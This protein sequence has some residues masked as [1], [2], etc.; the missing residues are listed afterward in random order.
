MS[1]PNPKRRPMKKKPAPRTPSP[2]RMAERPPDEAPIFRTVPAYTRWLGGWWVNA[3]RLTV[4]HVV[5]GGKVLED[6]TVTADRL[7]VGDGKRRYIVPVCFFEA[8]A[9]MGLLRY[10]GRR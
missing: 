3:A 7:M 9:E 5:P 8:A 6:G 4:Y 1:N 10:L 2:A